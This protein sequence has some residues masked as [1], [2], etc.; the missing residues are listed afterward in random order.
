[1]SFGPKNWKCKD[2]GRKHRNDRKQCVECGYSVLEPV[3]NERRASKLANAV[4]ALLPALLA[5]LTM[6]LMAWVLFF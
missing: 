2:C 3:D 6:G 1:M 5:I 4:L